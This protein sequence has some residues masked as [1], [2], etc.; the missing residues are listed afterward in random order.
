MIMRQAKILQPIH[1]GADFTLGLSGGAAHRLV[2]DAASGA[3]PQVIT[4][5]LTPVPLIG[6]VALFI[7]Q[8]LQQ[9]NGAGASLTSLMLNCFLA[10]G[11]HF[12]SADTLST[13][14]CSSLSETP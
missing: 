6:D 14:S 12:L 10:Q 7:D 1:E 9:L 4:A 13:H 2:A 3:A 11:R 5:P 8:N